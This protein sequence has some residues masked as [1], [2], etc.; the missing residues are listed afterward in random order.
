MR[1]LA[2]IVLLLQGCATMAVHN[3]ATTPTDVWAHEEGMTSVFVSSTHAL[4][5]IQE[6][7]KDMFYFYLEKPQSAENPTPAVF[8]KEDRLKSCDVTRFGTHAYKQLERCSVNWRENKAHYSYYDFLKDT[9]HGECFVPL[10]T[11]GYSLYIENRNT[12]VVVLNKGIV[13]S[14]KPYLYSLVLV[15]VPI[16]VVTSPI[17]ILMLLPWSP[18]FFGDGCK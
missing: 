15:S 1:C 4:A 2:V 16:D 10:G 6:P 7:D 3:L 8:R 14:E 9:D 12:D 13:G 17:Q 5:C 11:A 18:C